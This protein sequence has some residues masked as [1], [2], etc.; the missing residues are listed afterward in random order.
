MDDNI[1]FAPASEQRQLIARRE[2]SPVELTELYS[3]RIDKLDSRLN[4]Y[5]TL[6]RDEAMQTAKVA[7]ESVIHGEALGYIDRLKGRF[8]DLFETHDLLLSPTMAVP[9]F[10]VGE[11]PSEIDGKEVHPFWD[12][13]P[14]TY[15]I[16][17]IGNPAASVPCGFSSDGMPVGLHI[18]GRVGD[19]VTVL[20]ASAAFERARPWIS[21]RP[22]VS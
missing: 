21:H 14:F 16:N 2:I 20:A 5:L 7:E 10:P 13:L 6:I 12:Y 3:H 17:M 1:A 22:A 9:A 8:A 15:P 4:S 19:E 18:V 11:P